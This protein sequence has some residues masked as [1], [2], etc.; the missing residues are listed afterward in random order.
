M[1]TF[2]PSNDAPRTV[3]ERITEP[4]RDYPTPQHERETVMAA[5]STPRVPHY[6]P[7]TTFVDLTRWY[8]DPDSNANSLWLVEP[9]VNGTELPLF[10]L[11]YDDYPSVKSARR[12]AHRILGIPQEA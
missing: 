8:P 2:R 11:P 3:A 5:L 9:V 6:D 12:A 7:T 4:V 1:A 10:H